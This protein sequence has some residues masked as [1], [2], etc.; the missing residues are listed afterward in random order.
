MRMDNQSI[1][2][3]PDFNGWTKPPMS[4]GYLFNENMVA[5]SGPFAGK[6]ITALSTIPNG[7]LIAATES[8]KIITADFNEDKN[9]TFS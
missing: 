8:N 6:E 3:R 7:G 2:S 5:L 4:K 9:D 1:G